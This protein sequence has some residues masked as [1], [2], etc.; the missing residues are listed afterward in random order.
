V[1]RNLADPQSVGGLLDDYVGMYDLGE[2][3]KA[4][5]WRVGGR[6]HFRE[7][8]PDELYAIGE[9]VFYCRQ[10]PWKIEFSRDENF[11]FEEW[12]PKIKHPDS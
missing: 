8:A 11:A 12:W 10:E 3:A 5:V 1:L 2:H 6:L 7:F 9:D 4:T